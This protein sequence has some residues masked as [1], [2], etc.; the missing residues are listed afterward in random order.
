ML[1][2]ATTWRSDGL[3]ILVD[4]TSE[5][6]Y[7]GVNRDVYEAVNKLC[8]QGRRGE[9]YQML[10]GFSDKTKADVELAEGATV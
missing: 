1:F 7:Y 10:T 6:F 9:V 2:E 5:F 3:L 8:R 4:G